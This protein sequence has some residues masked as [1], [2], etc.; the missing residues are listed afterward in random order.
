[1]PGS[2]GRFAARAQLRLASIARMYVCAPESGPTSTFERTM[3]QQPSGV[4][5]PKP[6]LLAIRRIALFESLPDPV[7]QRVADDCAWRTFE[8]GRQIISRNADEHD[9]HLL[10]SGRIRVT[11][12]SSGGRQVTF[13]EIGP[14]EILG[15]L[16][17]ID[18]DRRSADAIAIDSVV[19]AAISRSAFLRLVHEEP[20]VAEGLIR[21]L[22]RE[23]RDLSERVFELSTAAVAQRIRVE[24]LRLARQAGVSDNQA[25]LAPAPR[26][27]DL[28]A[29]VG[30]YREQVTREIS[31]LV[32][33]GVLQREEH[34]ALRVTDVARLQAMCGD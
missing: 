34:R 8:A 21:R 15:E 19:T 29:Q 4:S 6:S 16:A 27:A 24:L 22:V 20:V 3:P 10:L 17:A 31:L 14:G 28:A 11:A 30:T 7:L 5:S 13:R 25:R 23:V 33:A 32:A 9:V 18:G 26:H 12:Y 2:A 1:M